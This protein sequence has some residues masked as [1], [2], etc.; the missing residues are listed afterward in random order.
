MRSL[1]RPTGSYRADLRSI[2]TADEWGQ[3]Q[4][5]VDRACRRARDYDSRFPTLNRLRSTLSEAEKLFLLGLYEG[6][7]K[8]VE[9]MKNRIRDSLDDHD[10]AWCRYCELGE[11][12]TFDHYLGKASV[13]ELALYAR[14]LL[15]CCFV[16]NNGRGATFD[17]DTGERRI[18][19]F[20]YDAVET[21]PT[22]IEATITFDQG[23]LPL[24]TFDLLACQHALADTF[25]K[26]FGALR[27]A[28][29]YRI[30]A[31]SSF[32]TLRTEVQRFAPN[33]PTLIAQLRAKIY[34]LES[35]FGPN[36]WHAALLTAICGC[37]RTL[38]WLRT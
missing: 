2:L 24:A 36:H 10:R 22:M 5:L 18:L 21:L 6:R 31:A 28:R 17:P 32:R 15:P 29:R 13:P 14:N 11:P 7:R 1:P 4:R 3:Q 16:C 27:L 23:G 12:V 19:H 25:R 30:R 34:S 35:E 8:G 26:H 20:F 37:P 33:E 9:R 38:T